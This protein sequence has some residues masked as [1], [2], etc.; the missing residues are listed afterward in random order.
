MDTMDLLLRAKDNDMAA[1]EEL[2][3]KY[4]G[5]VVHQAKNVFLSSYTFDDLIQT[6]IESILK[7]IN[8][9]DAT[10]GES[11]FNA[12]IF[13]CIKNNFNYLLRKEIRYN[14]VLSLDTLLKDNMKSMDFIESTENIEEV[15][16]KTVTT[17]EL[18]CALKLLDE[19]ELE[20]IRFL[21]LGKD[22]NYLS[23]YAKEKQKDY[24][25]C[26]S[27]KKRCLKKLRSSLNQYSQAI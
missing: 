26:T 6:G 20:L 23:R 27:L 8:S 4:Y 9:F 13:W 11:S 25:Y 10:K 2:I 16:L 14:Q 18:I 22:K 24:Y 12:Y 7:G 1:K 17:D 19:E 3:E 15:I 21:Y 5:L